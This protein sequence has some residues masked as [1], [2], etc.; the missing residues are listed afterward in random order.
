M[1]LAPGAPFLWLNETTITCRS[2]SPAQ[3]D[4]SDPILLFLSFIFSRGRYV[5][6]QGSCWQGRLRREVLPRCTTNAL[7]Q[8]QMYCIGRQNVTTLASTNEGQW[9]SKLGDSGIAIPRIRKRLEAL[10]NQ[11]SESTSQAMHCSI[12]H[13]P[14]RT[15]SLL[16]WAPRCPT[17][18]LPAQCP[19]LSCLPSAHP[20]RGKFSC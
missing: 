18:P 6:R 15:N 3:A 7:T 11:A 14:T 16:G 12:L 2:I 5:R 8:G 19:Q 10:I 13:V 17:S 1:Y 4:T 20:A 9:R